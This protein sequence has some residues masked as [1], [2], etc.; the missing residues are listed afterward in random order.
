MKKYKNL[1]FF[2]LSSCLLIFSIF[3]LVQITQFEGLKWFYFSIF[4][5]IDHYFFHFINWTPWKEKKEKEQVEKSKLREWIESI[6]FAIIAAT[7]IHVFIIQPYVIPTSSLEGTLLRGDFLFVSKFHYGSN[8]PNTPLFLP[9]MHNKLP[10][11]KN[12]PSYLDWIQLGYNRL[13]GFQKIKNNDLVVFNWPTDNLQENISSKIH[14]QY[15]FSIVLDNQL[16]NILFY[17]LNNHLMLYYN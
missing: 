10:F 9:F 6:T 15:I 14:I 12:T 4:C 8:V 16:K 1:L 11:T 13:P 17:V 3:I 5:L 2:I 7:L